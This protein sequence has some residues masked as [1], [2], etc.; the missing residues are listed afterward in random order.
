LGGAELFCK[1]VEVGRKTRLPGKMWWVVDGG[2]HCSW[3]TFF[4]R[5][6]FG[7]APRQIL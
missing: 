5:L 2:V 4:R 6:N 1:R 3:F 7:Y